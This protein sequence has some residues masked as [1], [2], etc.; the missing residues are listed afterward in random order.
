MVEYKDKIDIIKKHDFLSVINQ[1]AMK[2]PDRSKEGFDDLEASEE[3]EF[4]ETIAE[5]INKLGIWCLELYSDLDKMLAQ[6]YH[7]DYR[8]ILSF[9]LQKSV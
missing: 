5:I 8:V 6:E 4:F 3:E 7:A 9:V 1:F 2:F